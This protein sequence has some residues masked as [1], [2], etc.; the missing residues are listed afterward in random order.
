MRFLLVLIV[1]AFAGCDGSSE[2]STET[3]ADDLQESID[4]SLEKAEGVEETLQDA[5]DD[6]DAAID[7]ASGKD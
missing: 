3:V 7:E 6:L 2:N 1:V 4:T 5:V